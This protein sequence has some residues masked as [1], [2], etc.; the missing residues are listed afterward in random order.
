VA[1]SVDAALIIAFFIIT[2]TLIALAAILAHR[3]REAKE[4]ELKRAAS[5][6]GWSFDT[7]T[8]RGYR[9]HR[10]TGSTDGL[11]WRVESMRLVSGGKHGQNRR[12]HV[13][14]WHG[15]WSPGIS[16]HIVCMG[17]K[18]G[19]E[20]YSF[21]VAQGDGMFAKLAQ[22]AAGIM[23]DKAIDIYF[24][25]DLGKEVDAT[26][27]RR[28]ESAAIPGFIVMAANKDEGERV[29]SQGLQRALPNVP[30]DDTWVL[31]R[32][33]GISLAR[34]EQIREVGEIDALIRAGLALKSAFTFGRPSPF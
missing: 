29:L 2:A 24:G 1:V 6:R 17:V 14:R 30:Y 11:A 16:G 32:P 28:V 7:R 21:S 10:W 22:K 25:D 23:F 8:E 19:A 33:L 26:A 3:R 4:E 13:S 31:L 15:A 27:L 9:I 34:M 5:Q 20:V 18:K 12:H